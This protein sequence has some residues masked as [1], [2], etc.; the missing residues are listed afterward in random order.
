MR[1][2]QSFA[3][4]QNVTSGILD[5]PLTDNGLQQA[6]EASVIVSNLP[7]SVDII[8]HS[9]LSRARN[10]ASVIAAVTDA[11]MVEHPGLNE[12]DFGEW[13]GELWDYVLEQ[14][15]LGREPPGGETDEIFISRVRVTLNQILQSHSSNNIPM[16]V[17]HGGIFYAISRLYDCSLQHIEN[18]K[19]YL[20][21]P[22]IELSIPWRTWSVKYVEDKCHFDL[23]TLFYIK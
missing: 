6:R 20:F 15:M 2:G 16:L 8:Y 14:L 1:H 22:A 9:A 10:T 5:T 21:E 19:L 17:A 3:N 13:E 23:E 4:I 18:S 11:K 12:H 7:H